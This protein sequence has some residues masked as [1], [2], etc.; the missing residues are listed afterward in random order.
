M[1]DLLEWNYSFY[2]SHETCFDTLGQNFLSKCYLLKTKDVNPATESCS[3]SMTAYQLKY[4]IQS[5]VNPYKRSLGSNFACFS[6]RILSDNF[7]GDMVRN[8]GRSKKEIFQSKSFPVPYEPR[9]LP[10]GPYWLNRFQC[11]FIL[12]MFQNT[13]EFQM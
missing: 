6:D 3:Q 5:K 12:I 10:S 13:W 2:S 8:N 7:M 9:Y 4:K 11:V 1:C